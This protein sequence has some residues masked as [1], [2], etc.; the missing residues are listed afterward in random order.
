MID[1]THPDTNLS[2]EAREAI[3]ARLGLEIYD[4][5]W[6][7]V[8]LANLLDIDLEAAFEEKIAFNAKREWKHGAGDIQ[9][10]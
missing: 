1:L 4:L 6:N 5:I 7:A 10:E 9:D 2:N 3:K 8:D